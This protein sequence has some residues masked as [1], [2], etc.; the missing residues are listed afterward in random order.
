MTRRPISMVFMIGT[1]LL[2]AVMVAPVVRGKQGA[3]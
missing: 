1:M 3:G 2:L